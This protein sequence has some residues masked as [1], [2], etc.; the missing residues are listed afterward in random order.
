[1]NM[2][3]YLKSQRTTTQ[4]DV[5]AQARKNSS[6]DYKPSERVSNDV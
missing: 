4:E 3:E 5:D 1:M 2:T 6:D